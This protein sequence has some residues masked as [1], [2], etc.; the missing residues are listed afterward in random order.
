M[1][2]LCLV[3]NMENKNKILGC[4]AALL[5]NVIFGFSFI[6]SKLALSVAHP[7]TILCVRFVVAFAALNLLI[8]VGLV[9]INLKGKKLGKLIA[10]GIAQPLLHFTF[11]L[12]GLAMV[13]SALSGVITSL[14][15]VAVMII[16]VF[17][18]E[19]PTFIQVIC[20][21]VSIVGV[22][23]VSMLSF[24]GAKSHLLGIILL[25]CAVISASVF[26]I[27]SRSESAVFSPFEKTYMMFLI[28]SIGFTVIAVSVLRGEFIS[29]IYKAFSSAKF[30]GAEFY[31]AIV[32]SLLAFMLY[33]FSTSRINAIQAS[34]FSN[35][36]TVV[37]IIAGVV[38]L[39]EEF[40]PLQFIICAFIILGVWGV[41][42]FTKDREK[43]KSADR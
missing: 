18:G 36:I 32:S 16:C 19:K 35:I 5:A 43:A 41:N 9:K 20:T 29:E 27:L 25:V 33:N 28:G 10:M 23:V 40:S 3:L 17:L 1:I 38:F 11:E 7:L 21:I 8:L 13:S 15:P 34:S 39:K 26:N 2:K 30:I 24:D 4:S 31:L 42:T 6:F 14:V 37:S 12:Y 22:S